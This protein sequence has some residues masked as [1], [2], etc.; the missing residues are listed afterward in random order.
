MR[1]LLF[2]L[3]LCLTTTLLSAADKP[4]IILMMADDLGWGDVGYNGHDR[5]LTPHLD[6]MA[7][8]G[9]RFNR[10]YAAAPVCSP[11]RGSCITGRHPYRYGIYFANTGHLPAEEMNLAEFLKTQ[12]YATGHFG[13][14]HLGTLTKEVIDANRG[15]RDKQEEHYA[16]PWDRGFDVCFSTESKVPTYDPL[17][18]PEGRAKQKFFNLI[19]PNEPTEP[20]N[21][22]YWTGPGETATDN[23]RGDDSRVIMDRV[24]PF[25]K[26][27]AR[28]EKPFF[29]VV[30][31]H[32]PHWPVV[33]GPKHKEPYQD[34]DDF[35]Q[36][37]YGCITALDEQVGR[38]RAVLQAAGV[39][40]NTLLTFCS[41]NGPEG[42]AKTGCGTAKH[43][44]GRKRDLYEGGVRVPGLMVWPDR[45]PEP[46]VIDAPCSTEDYFPTV[47]A[48]FE[49]TLPKEKRMP[50]DGVNFLPIIDGKQTERGSYMGFRSRKQ[51]AWTGD[52]YKLF[53]D[54]DGKTWEL[55]DLREDE[56][57]S[58]NIAKNKPDLVEQLTKD[59]NTWVESLE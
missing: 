45:F 41:D 35:H 49:K 26:E 2:S 12:G 20:Y 19:Q 42:S 16:P 40:D 15:G 46:K 1:S 14:W 31:F 25:V 36:N 17:L 34:L 59:L 48:I 52:R 51:L 22:R 23:M 37:Y 27:H 10:F 33:A 56:S 18:K 29:A 30:W 53:S 3:L 57:E 54:N 21:T 58:N 7:A 6:R 4:N 28:N 43:L 44:R 24:I 39:A 47:L 11:T 9:I 32:A 50:F 13:K 55:Y 38:L 5:L 8:E